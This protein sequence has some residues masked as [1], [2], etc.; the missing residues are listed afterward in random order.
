[1]LYRSSLVRRRWDKLENGIEKDVKFSEVH[2][3][4]TQTIKLINEETNRQLSSEKVYQNNEEIT[5]WS[6][7]NTPKFCPPNLTKNEPETATLS[8]S[9]FKVNMDKSFYN[10]WRW[11]RKKIDKTESSLRFEINSLVLLVWVGI[12]FEK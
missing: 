5:E 11:S 3:N 1:M 4:I 6:C 2:E 12:W 10:D 7:S 9:Y 8:K